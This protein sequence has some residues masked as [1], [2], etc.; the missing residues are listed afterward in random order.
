MTAEYGDQVR[1]LLDEA[2]ALGYGAA[3][4]ALVEEAVRLADA[5]Q[6]IRLGFLARK[7]LLD[8]GVFSGAEQA[9]FVAFSW[10]LAWCD[11]DPQ[12]FPED[13]VLWE[14]KWI[15]GNS[16]DYPQITRAQIEA[17]FA[18]AQRRYERCGRGVRPI[19]KLRRLHAA[20]RGDRA[21]ARRWHRLW[22]RTLPGR[23]NDCAACDHNHEV[24]YL[25]SQ[26]KDAAALDCAAPILNGRMRCTVVPHSTLGNVLLPLVR[27]GRVEEAASAHRK[28]YRLISGNRDF[29]PTA[30]KHL[31]FLTVTGNLDRAV[32]VFEKHLPWCFEGTSPDSQFAFYQAARFLL[33]Q[34]LA[35][36][37]ETVAARLPAAVPFGERKSGR[38]VADLKG[39]F[40]AEAAGIAGRFDE[41]NGNTYFKRRLSEP[42]RWAK[43]VTP[44]PLGK[45]AR[46][47]DE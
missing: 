27:L 29:L 23:G 13:D 12:R 46:L 15:L 24:S 28:G 43:L 17:L 4:T 39:Y 30:G 40:D 36:G 34:L 38:K 45:P 3:K 8:A 35:A 31:A 9:A 20:E 14:Y 11:R 26:G 18:D 41:R 10:C 44:H 21:E 2:A 42:K 7:R 25:I 37:R 5:H 16:G 1:R 22:L 19:Y 32:R 47:S 33:G 6:D